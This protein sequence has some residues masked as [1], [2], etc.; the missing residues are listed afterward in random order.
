MGIAFERFTY[1][2]VAIAICSVIAF[3]IRVQLLTSGEMAADATMAGSRASVA[4]ASEQRSAVVITGT[5]RTAVSDSGRVADRAARNS[6]QKYTLALGELSDL[7]AAFEERDRIHVLTG[8]ET[9][10]VPAADNSGPHRIVLGI[11]RSPERE[12]AVARM[13]LSSRTLTAATV[14]VLPKREARQ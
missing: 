7:Q 13:L 6:T 10:V 8:M 1:S 9:W 3:V 4:A 11:Y 14:V 12:Q 5:S 2:L